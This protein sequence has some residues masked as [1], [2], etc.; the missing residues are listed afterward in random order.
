[1]NN[2][3]FIVVVFL[4][5]SAIGAGIMAAGLTAIAATPISSP[6]AR[7]G[8]SNRA[9]EFARQIVYVAPPAP[10]PQLRLTPLAPPRSETAETSH[11]SIDDLLGGPSEVTGD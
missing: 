11:Y 5:S 10:A 3:A 6:G 8:L 7:S 1:M 2:I 4:I 9:P